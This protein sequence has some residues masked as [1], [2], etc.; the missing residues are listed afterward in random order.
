M[1]L[2]FL[3]D[4]EDVVLDHEDDNIGICAEGKHGSSLQ[5]DSRWHIISV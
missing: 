3:V 4:H 1:N 5:R 2:L